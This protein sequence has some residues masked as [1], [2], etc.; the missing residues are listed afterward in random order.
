MVRLY[1]LS[2]STP[3]RCVITS[4]GCTRYR[5]AFHHSR[6]PNEGTKPIGCLTPLF[7]FSQLSPFASL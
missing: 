3:K 5:R 2:F 4:S 7:Q 1:L 6:H